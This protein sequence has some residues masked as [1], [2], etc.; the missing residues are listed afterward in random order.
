[1][2]PWA[3]E[4]LQTAVKWFVGSSSENVPLQFVAA[5]MIRG[6]DNMILRK[7]SILRDRNGVIQ[8]RDGEICGRDGMLRG[9]DGACY[10]GRDGMCAVR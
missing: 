8:E 10:W 5:G 2:L 9:R 7:Q 3:D 1:M 4:E 6:R